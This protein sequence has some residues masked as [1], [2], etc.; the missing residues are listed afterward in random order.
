MKPPPLAGQ[1]RNRPSVMHG[2][3]YVN[4]VQA[5]QQG[6]LGRSFGCPAVRPAI[7]SDMIDK[8]KEGQLVFAYYPDRQWLA[9][10]RFF[11]CRAKLAGR[12]DRN[13]GAGGL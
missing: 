12:G 8:L 9:N 10:S 3:S 6:R 7:A 4:P 13:T 2:A 11:R 1:P 5:L